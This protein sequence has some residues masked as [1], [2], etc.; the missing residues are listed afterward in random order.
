MCIL[1]WQE[2]VSEN[3]SAGSSC[4]A[5]NPIRSKAILHDLCHPRDLPEAPSLTPLPWRGAVSASAKEFCEDTFSP[6]GVGNDNPLQCSCR[7]FHGQ[8]HLAGCSSCGHKKVSH[9]WA[10]MHSAH[11]SVH[12]GQAGGEERANR[13]LRG[14]W[15]WREALDFQESRRIG[16]HSRWR[17]FC[18]QPGSDLLSLSVPGQGYMYRPRGEERGWVGG[19]MSCTQELVL[20]RD[21]RTCDHGGGTHCCGSL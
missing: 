13:F 1:T 5:T 18:S 7:K 15:R 2:R 17:I 11:Q 12:R 20:S 19:V 10:C 14:M 6:Y 16:S 4:E 3:N 21:R 9:D 8:R